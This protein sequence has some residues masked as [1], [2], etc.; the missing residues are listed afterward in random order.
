[1][2]NAVLERTTFQT[3]RVEDFFSTH[4]LTAQ[5]GQPVG[6][7]A[8]VVM[9][10]AESDDGGKPGIYQTTLK[11][12]QPPFQSGEGNRAGRNRHNTRIV[13]EYCSEKG[14][15]HAGRCARCAHNR[16]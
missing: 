8:D 16:G 1:M 9:K 6:R 7:F 2:K 11:V 5:T 14:T 15:G 13:R 3:S 12:P 4:E 10:E